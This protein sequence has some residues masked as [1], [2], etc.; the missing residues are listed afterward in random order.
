MVGGIHGFFLQTRVMETA[1]EI[2]RRELIALLA[3]ATALT[4][5]G[6]D[7]MLPAFNDIRA[8]LGLAADSTAGASHCRCIAA[9]SWSAGL[10]TPASLSWGMSPHILSSSVLSSMTRRA[11]KARRAS[12]TIVPIAGCDGSGVGR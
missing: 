12:A 11:F 7:L 1:E 6:I 8:D 2:G 5:L 4:A 9:R 10:S 3:M